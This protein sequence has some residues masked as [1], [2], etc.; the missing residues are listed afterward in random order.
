MHLD[1]I[2]SYKNKSK[3]NKKSTVQDAI[4][5]VELVKFIFYKKK[6]ARV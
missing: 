5:S 6:Y 1:L 4:K 3:S 2:N